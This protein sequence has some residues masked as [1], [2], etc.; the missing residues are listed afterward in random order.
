MLSSACPSA[1]VAVLSMIVTVVCCLA[2][3]LICVLWLWTTTDMVHR[4]RDQIEVLMEQ[5]WQRF[6]R[7]IDRQQDDNP[8]VRRF[9]VDP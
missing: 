1:D 6:W 2:L 3:V 7:G 9:E 8:N 4:L 5:I